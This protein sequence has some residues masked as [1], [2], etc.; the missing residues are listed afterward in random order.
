VG[1]QGSQFRFGARLFSV[2]AR[3]K[4]LCRPTA[5]RRSACPRM[6]RLSTIYVYLSALCHPAR[7]TVVP[8]RQPVWPLQPAASCK[9]QDPQKKRSSWINAADP[10]TAP[11]TQ[12]ALTAYSPSHRSTTRPSPPWEAQ[13]Q[14]TGFPISTLPL[15]TTPALCLSV[16]PRPAYDAF[17]ISSSP[18]P[19]PTPAARQ[20][21]EDQHSSF[22]VH[23]SL[24]TPRHSRPLHLD[25]VLG[26]QFA[27]IPACRPAR[28]HI[29][30]RGS[31]HT[32]L[33][34]HRGL[35]NRSREE[36]HRV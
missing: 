33:S 28:D 29:R 36:G 25:R 14:M 17:F 1:G 16:R 31:R 13:V 23:C 27:S 21:F 7:R 8:N 9:Q 24:P 18:S 30:F 10:R 11:P 6:L 19:F 3:S 20:L 4:Y 34:H 12:C 26:L 5:M 2:P 35:L 22:R 15:I 32:G